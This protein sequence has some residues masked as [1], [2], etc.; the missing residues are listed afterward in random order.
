LRLLGL[1]RPAAIALSSLLASGVSEEFKLLSRRS[2][3]T[4]EIADSRRQN[5]LNHLDQVE[6][7]S[8]SD[9][10]KE[11]MEG[12]IEPL[13]NETNSLNSSL[14][15]GLD[16][17][18]STSTTINNDIDK[19]Q[20]QDNYQHIYN[21]NGT[22]HNKSRTI[23]S[24]LSFDEFMVDLTRWIVY[25]FLIES[26]PFPSTSKYLEY[27]EYLG[28]GC[29]S[30]MSGR[31][32][33]KFLLQRKDNYN[34]ENNYNNDTD[35]INDKSN[36]IINEYRTR[37]MSLYSVSSNNEALLFAFAALEGGVLFVIFQ[38]TYELCKH[39][40]PNELQEKM[41]INMLF[42]GIETSLNGNKF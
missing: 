4:R 28:S 25:D 41:V 34:N 18:I 38:I 33:G 36:I 8:D 35:I 19:D 29:L 42:E 15:L 17:I 27:L 6:V 22:T 20:K 31:V 21:C 39:L 3:I 10:K 5:E 26:L 13:V 23:S 32:M 40:L 1:P 24:P 11:E 9:M 12:I 37:E 7:D 14:C 2:Q 30:G 16:S